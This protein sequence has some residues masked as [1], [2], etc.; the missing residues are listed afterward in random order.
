MD[1]IPEYSLMDY[2]EPEAQIDLKSY[3]A[4]LADTDVI[5]PTGSGDFEDAT[6]Q[7]EERDNPSEPAA[8]LSRKEQ[9]RGYATGGNLGSEE[10]GSTSDPVR[11]FLRDIGDADLL[12]RDQEMALAQQLEAARATMLAALCEYPGTFSVIGA[13]REALRDGRIKL[14]DLVEIDAASANA[15]TADEA[16]ETTL[17]DKLRPEILL[18]LDTILSAGDDLLAMRVGSD[19][20]Y[21][22]RGQLELV[23]DK[24]QR[25]GLH[26]SRI[27]VLTAAIKRASG[28]LAALDREALS[29]ALAAGLQRPEF[30]R[31]WNHSVEAALRL[32]CLASKLDIGAEIERL[33]DDTGLPIAELHR[34]VRD[35][36]RGEREARRATDALTRAHLRLVVHIAK[37]Y[38]NRGLMFSDLIQ[39]GNLGLMRAIEK[40]DWRRGVKLST[41]ATWWIRQ[42]MSRAIADQAPTIRVPVHMT[43]T[44]GQVRR[45]SWSMARQTGREP[46]LEELA[47]KLGMSVDKVKTAQ[48]LVREPMSLETPIGDGE[49]G[50]L[51][52]LVVDRNA[53]MPFEA[54]TRSALRERASRLLSGL[55]PREERILRMR[56]GIGMDRDHTLEEVGQ[57]FNVTRERIRQIEAKALAKLKACASSHALRE[58]LGA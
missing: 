15:A 49:D 22:Y 51:G 16:T 2:D 48:Q 12:T 29:L 13:W 40:F 27:D 25:L 50:E 52:D 33:E 47:A 58:L 4:D 7:S 14:R 30:L 18:H 20:G 56:F 26:R 41:Y 23:V 5:G 37:R 6:L 17:G 32:E 36:S 19:Q 1:R 38:R 44:A 53:V 3:E 28:R 24:V 8:D 57:T 42:A 39:E 45:T 35:L 10:S 31:L 46:M 43:E 54:A 55:T 34:I 9:D 21:R 11:M